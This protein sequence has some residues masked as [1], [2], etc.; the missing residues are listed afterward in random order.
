MPQAGLE[1]PI[2]QRVGD[3]RRPR[4]LSRS[5]WLGCSA[6]VVE[7]GGPEVGREGDT[8]TPRD[9]NDGVVANS[10]IGEQPAH[11]VGLE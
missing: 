7:V 9:G 5:L 6:P 1:V 11:G 4:G 8:D 3:P 10:S 2:R